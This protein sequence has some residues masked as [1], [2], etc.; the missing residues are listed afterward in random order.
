MGAVYARTGGARKD[1][2]DNDRPADDLGF[3]ISDFRFEIS[4]G[5]FGSRLS[6]RGPRTANPGA[7]GTGMVARSSQH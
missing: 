3:Q 4:D 5:A 6:N 1:N 2:S 7:P